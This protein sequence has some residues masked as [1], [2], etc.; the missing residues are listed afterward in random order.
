MEDVSGF[1]Q[2]PKASKLLIVTSSMKDVMVLRELG[3]N[4]IAFNSEGIPTKGDKAEF[5]KNTLEHLKTRFNN[6]VF[7]MDNDLPGKNYSLKLTSHYR[8]PHMLIP[9]NEPKDISDYYRKYGKR[10]TRRML[11]KL[12]KKIL[13]PELITPY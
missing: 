9:D 11:Q 2:L 5:V 7:F 1:Y 12:L 4:A 8:L 13:N 10:R 3:Y 6:I